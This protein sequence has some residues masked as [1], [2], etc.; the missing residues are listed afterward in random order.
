LELEDGTVVRP[1]ELLRNALIH[2]TDPEHPDFWQCPPEQ[3]NNQRQVEASIVA[4]SLWLAREQILP[5]LSPRQI[6]N[7]QKWLESCTRF[8]NLFNNWSLFFAVNHA[9]RMALSKWG[10][11]GDVEEVRRNLIVGDDLYAGDGWMYDSKNNGLDYYNFWV[12]GS[13]HHYLRAMLGDYQNPVID[14]ALERAAIRSADLPYLI[15]ASGR[16]ILFG[17]SLAYRWGW[18]SGLIA[19]AFNGDRPV[20]PGLTRAM[21]ARNIESW[22]AMGALNAEGGMHERITAQG[23]D[24]GRDGY[25]NCGHPYWGMQAFL[26]LYFPSNHAFWNAPAAELPIDQGDFQIARQGPGMV[27]QGL[28]RSGEVRLFNFRNLNNHMAGN[29]L[30]EKFVYSSAYPCDAGG[31]HHT[32]WDNQFAVRLADGSHVPPKEILFVDVGRAGQVELAWKFQIAPDCSAF[33]RTFLFIEGE[34]YRT[35][36]AIRVAGP[37]PAG[38]QWV[39]GGFA[40]HHELRQVPGESRKGDGAW[41]RNDAAGDA[42]MTENLGGWETLH[43]VRGWRGLCGQVDLSTGVNIVH[44]DAD[45]F[46]LTAPVCAEAVSLKARHGAGPGI[47][48]AAERNPG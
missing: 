22:L 28:H 24:G 44:E 26:C 10:F 25:I 27:F 42:V 2:G 4:W 47:F 43:D 34:C 41:A 8:T 32:C 40:L 46:L 38:A 13:H 3:R 15:D 36:H 16:N 48:A 7:L 5:T 12:N 14:R 45:H 19:A 31:H 18:L 35:E 33:V 11:S 9:A 29:A 39:E 17:R 1:A 23:S 20:N 6:A 37:I 21:L 30:Y